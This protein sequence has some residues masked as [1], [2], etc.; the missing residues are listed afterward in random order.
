M[1]QN[2]SL[3]P[4]GDFQIWGHQELCLGSEWQPFSN[5]A[6]KTYV[7]DKTAPYLQQYII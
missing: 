6:S 3:D 5:T 7:F 4:Y 1:W 2:F